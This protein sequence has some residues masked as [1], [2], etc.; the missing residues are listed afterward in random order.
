MG[1]S[2][3]KNKEEVLKPAEERNVMYQ[4]KATTNINVSMEYV[5]KFLLQDYK[6]IVI[7]FFSIIE[8][9]SQ[10][11]ACSITRTYS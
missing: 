1:Q 10:S 7:D 2:G 11:F 4:A 8:C 6:Q 5:F 9:V 3:P